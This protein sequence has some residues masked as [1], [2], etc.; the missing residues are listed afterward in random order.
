MLILLPLPYAVKY[1]HAVS[2]GDIEE[3]WGNNILKGVI[4]I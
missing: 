3:K 1:S 2:C 4:K